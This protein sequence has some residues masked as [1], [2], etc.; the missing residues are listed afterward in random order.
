MKALWEE[1]SN[2]R[3]NC[4][5][6]KCTCE[7]VK[8][9]NSFYQNEYIMTFLTDLNDSFFQVRGQ[10][11]LMDPL[12]AINKV[13]SL[14]SQAERQRKIGSQLS[15]NNDSTTNMAF[16]VNN[17]QNARSGS[18][19]RSISTRGTVP[20]TG[21]SI[22]NDGAIDRGQKKERPFCTYCNIP[23]HIIERCYKLHGYPP[24][25]KS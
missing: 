5:C 20:N 7:G 21:R 10:L 22:G 17:D 1:L 25:F 11:L 19:S 8:K 3:P 13:F 16:M 24:G 12:P 23:G 18:T 9:L 6:G 14:I 4:S 2:F 15:L